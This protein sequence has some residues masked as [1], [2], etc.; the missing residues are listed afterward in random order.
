[1]YGFPPNVGAV[2]TA[3]LLNVGNSLGNI[4]KELRAQGYSVGDLGR[5]PAEGKYVLVCVGEFMR[6]FIFIYALSTFSPLFD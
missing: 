1:M 4:L 2:G 3:A 6:V 5:G